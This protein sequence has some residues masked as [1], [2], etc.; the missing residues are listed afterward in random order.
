MGSSDQ[1]TEKASHG[2]LFR[3]PGISLL[4]E[5]DVALY[6]VDA[7]GR[8]VRL[9]QACERLLGYSEAEALGQNM[10]RL[11]HHHH[12]DG[13]PFD[14][15]D[16][17]L[18]QARDRRETLRDAR[19]TM[20]AVD[21]SAVEVECSASPVA[22]PDGTACTVVTMKDVRGRVAAENARLALETEQVEA[23][24]QVSASARILTEFAAETMERQRQLQESVER[25]AADQIREQQQLLS[26]VA[27]NAPVGIAVLDRNV[28]HLWTN[29]SY[30]HA[31]DPA[32]QGIPLEG[33]SLFDVVP[34]GNLQEMH[35]IVEKVQCTGETFLAESYAL[36]GVGRGTTYW[37]WSLSRLQN[38][39]LMSTAANVT[40]QVHARRE[41]EAVYANAPIAL[42]LLDAKTLCYLR[43][44][45]RYAEMMGVSQE[46]ML[47]CRVGTFSVSQTGALLAKAAVG[48]PM[49]NALVR[50]EILAN[51]GMERHLLVNAVPNYDN[52][53]SIE[54]ISLALTDVTAQKRAEDALL[55]ADKLAAVG[56]LAASISHE[57]NNPLEAVTNL[58]YLIH[59][60]PALSEESCIYVEQ[61]EEELRRVSQIASQTLRFQRHAV[62][63]VP[64]TARQLIDPVVAMYQGRLK[65]TRI[66]ISVDYRD[67]QNAVMVLEGDVRQILNNLLGNAI[68]ATPSGGKI[69]VRAK[70]ARCI[71]TRRRGTRISIADSGHGMSRDIAEHIFEPFFTTKG[72]AGS[73]LGLWISHTLVHR[74]GGQLGVRSR[75]A[76]SSVNGKSGTVFSLFLPDLNDS[77][78]EAR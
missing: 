65:H 3:S 22:L 39:D 16:C 44:N 12:A 26:M 42:G 11:V 72:S 35:A 4:D 34:P 63:A 49:H 53:G 32:F 31:M 51:P 56:R 61:A 41:V 36:E 23:I 69:V 66:E 58:L 20:W 46:Q 68:D 57:I 14:E 59:L 52:S 10:H 13:S 25:A 5:I 40:E 50:I 38:G 74:H 17:R 43:V 73:G 21:G 8:C 1:S 76:E 30:A 60:D 54:T 9:N 7:A 33:M 24:R 27:Q 55:Q 2:G 77:N 62:K 37:R 6:A 45:L 48:Q 15:K 29:E 47:G 67:D 19:E 28:C 64:V 75:R 78:S 71:H 70:P 18:M